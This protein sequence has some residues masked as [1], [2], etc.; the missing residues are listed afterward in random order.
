MLAEVADDPQ[1]LEDLTLLDGATNDRVQGEHHG[2]SGIS[3]FELVYGIPN[4][5]IVNAAFTHSSRSG[6]RF[7]DETRGGWYAAEE[8]DTSI[9]EVSYHK[10]RRLSE[11]IVPDLPGERPDQDLSTYD[12]WLADFDGEFHMLEPAGEFSEYLQPEPVPEC[13]ANS[14]RLAKELLD[15]QSNGLIYPSVRRA[16]ATCIVCF[17]PALVFHPRRSQRYEL[18]LTATEQG[19]QHEVHSVPLPLD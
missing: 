3:V 19:Y 12:D 1:M 6:S 15:R 4:A 7:S 11:I 18:R 14:Q 10:A 13:Y 17:R 8:L 9:A 2:L 5:H 16:G